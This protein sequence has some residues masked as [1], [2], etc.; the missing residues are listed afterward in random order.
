MTESK[1]EHDRESRW[2]LVLMI[3]VVVPITTTVTTD[4]PLWPS[5]GLA[6]LIGVGVGSVFVLAF[7]ILKRWSQRAR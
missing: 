2:F 5:L 1:R 6:L 4:M 7:K 3:A